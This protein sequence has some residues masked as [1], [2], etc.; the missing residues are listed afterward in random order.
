MPIETVFPP[1]LPLT[2]PV[3]IFLIVLVIIF[4]TQNL[5]KKTPVPGIMGMILAG[6]IVGPHGLNFLSR[7]GGITLFG[8]VGLLYV[9]FLAGAEIDF[10]QLRKGIFRGGAFGLLTFLIPMGMGVPLGMY[11]FG[12]S[13]PASLLLA[14]MFASHTLISYP[15]LGKLGVS[16]SP[17]VGVT[18]AGT[19][20]TDILALLILAVVVNFKRGDLDAWFWMKLVWS[21]GVF[22]IA[23]LSGVPK[24]A[25]LF[26]KASDDDSAA[27]YIFVLGMLFLSAFLAQIA[28]FEAIIGAFLAGLALNRFMPAGSMLMSR[29]EFVG[30]ALFIP[31]FLIGVGMLV[32]IRALFSGWDSLVIGGAMSIVAIIAKWMPAKLTRFAFKYSR[33]EGNLIFGLSVAQAA[34]TL[35]VVMIAFEMGL[36]GQSI[37]NGTIMMILVTCLV[38]S[39]VTQSAGQELAVVESSKAFD[40]EDAPQRIMVPIANPLNIE[41]L[42]DLAM[43]LQLP[44]SLEPIF[45]LF[46]VDEENLKEKILRNRAHL[47]KTIRYTSAAEK[48]VHVLSSVD[49]NVA[50]GVIRAAK[51]LMATELIVGWNGKV[52]ESGGMFGPIIDEVFARCS[53]QVLVSRIRDPLNVINR[54]RVMIPRGADREFGYQHWMMTVQ[55]LARR[56]GGEIQLNG[57]GAIV[58]KTESGFH[59]LFGNH[60]IEL[61]VS[62]DAV[63]RL[64]PDALD[65]GEMLIVISARRGGASFTEEMTRTPSVLAERFPE[66][67]VLVVYPEL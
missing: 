52:S 33:V 30:Q 47:I 5:L 36:F 50:N 34:A 44:G 51:E 22:V 40:V 17:V 66:G 49:G 46:V 61:K 27:Q 10:Q 43:A 12:L 31:F 24:L 62:A 20:I 8:K 54:L 13:F 6:M 1:S 59:R 26:F 29:V 45:P 65:D 60:N 56:C 9:M 16:R 37:L 38:S 14:S 42:L 19:I 7:D 18:V 39:L 2:D 32:D 21:F 64:L 11:G 23:V 55:A 63:S 41:R 35:A 53:A 25:G 15:V 58:K 4:L 48:N 67:N 28:G 3:L 57:S